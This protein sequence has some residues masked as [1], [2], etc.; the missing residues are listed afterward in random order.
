VPVH[1]TNPDY[2]IAP[3]G[4]LHIV[5]EKCCEEFYLKARQ[6]GVDAHKAFLLELIQG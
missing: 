3:D 6:A 4:N 1:G 2:Q 5:M